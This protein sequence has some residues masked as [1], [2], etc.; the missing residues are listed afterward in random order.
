M[1]IRFLPIAHH[2]TIHRQRGETSNESKTDLIPTM[3]SPPKKMKPN[4]NTPTQDENA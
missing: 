3:T 1:T 4:G 2:M